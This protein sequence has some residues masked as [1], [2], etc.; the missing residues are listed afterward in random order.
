[1]AGILH[2]E[3][4]IIWQ[5][6]WKIKRAYRFNVTP[7]DLRYGM[8]VCDQNGVW[9]P[10]RS[11]GV[12]RVLSLGH[13]LQDT[14]YLVTFRDWE[15]NSINEKDHSSSA[16]SWSVQATSDTEFLVFDDDGWHEQGFIPPPEYFASIDDLDRYLSDGRIIKVRQRAFEDGDHPQI[17]STTLWRIESLG[18]DWVRSIRVQTPTGAF[19]VGEGCIPVRTMSNENER[20]AAEDILTQRFSASD[21]WSTVS[22]TENGAKNDVRTFSN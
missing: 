11:S 17:R 19:C 6:S 5:S 2:R 12:A 21:N 8:E 18:R 16:H 13:M 7:D 4:I 9:S 3:Q 1:M 20:R 22:R 10:S 15:T 14:V